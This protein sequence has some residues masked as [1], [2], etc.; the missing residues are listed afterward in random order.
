MYRP[1][2]EIAPPSEDFSAPVE[3]PVN[4]APA[5]QNSNHLHLLLPIL[6]LK[7]KK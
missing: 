7:K 5:P 4:V 6:N 2:I 3:E 1:K